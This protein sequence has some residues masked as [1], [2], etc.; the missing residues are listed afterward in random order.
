[1]QLLLPLFHSLMIRLLQDQSEQ[2]NLLQ[3]LALKVFYTLIQVWY[4]T[5]K[6]DSQEQNSSHSYFAVRATVR[7]D[8]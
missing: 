3:K 5:R 2:S 6:P 1:M 8:F 7:N 4:S